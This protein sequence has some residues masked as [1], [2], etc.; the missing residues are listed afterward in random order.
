MSTRDEEPK[1]AYAKGEKKMLLL[2][3]THTHLTG[4]EP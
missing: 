4:A 2:A 3:S 1:A